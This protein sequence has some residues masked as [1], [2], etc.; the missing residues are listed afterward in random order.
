M[1][2]NLLTLLCFV[3]WSVALSQSDKEYLAG[4]INYRKF[5]SIK[6]SNEER[7][8]FSNL[9]KYRYDVNQS[10]I[11]DS[12]ESFDSRDF[13]YSV[14]FDTVKYNGIDVRLSF[15]VKKEHKEEFLKN[16]NNKNND[17]IEKYLDYTWDTFNN[18]VRVK[19]ELTNSNIKVNITKTKDWYDCVI[20]KE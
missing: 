8:Y 6:L 5:E 20:L 3:V 7:T 10:I 18:K 15:V 1:K 16:C 13:T 14:R 17:C 11:F 4:S 2:K 12:R 19:S 9:F